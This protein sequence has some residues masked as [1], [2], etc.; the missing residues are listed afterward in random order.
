M[1]RLLKY[2]GF[3]QLLTLFVISL[4]LSAYLLRQNNLMMVELREKV[5]N[6]DEGSNGNIEKIEP[7]LQELKDYVTSH[8]NTTMQSPVQLQYRYNKVVDEIIAEN[9]EKATAYRQSVYKKAEA[10]CTA[11]LQ[12]IRVPCIQE[13]ISSRPGVEPLELP[14]VEQFSYEF[15]S[16]VLS[17]DLAGLSVVVSVLLGLVVSFLLVVDYALPYVISMVR[18]DPLE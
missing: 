5:V 9:E 16:P 10:N 17:F 7:A 13:Y 6:I 18:D 14:P 12:S 8:M 4:F 2:F 11:V 3:W 15:T 1:N